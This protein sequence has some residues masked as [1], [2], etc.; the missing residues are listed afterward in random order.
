VP[1]PAEV[2]GA[3]AWQVAVPGRRQPL[4]VVADDIALALQIASDRLG[5]EAVAEA[6]AWRLG[7]ILRDED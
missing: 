6:R 3:Y 4:L 5:A 1:T 7:P 2:L